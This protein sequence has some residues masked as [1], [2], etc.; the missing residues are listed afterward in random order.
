MSVVHYQDSTHLVDFAEVRKE[1]NLDW[2]FE[3]VLGCEAQKASGALRYSVCPNPECGAGPKSSVKV[4]TRNGV[5]QCCRCQRHGDVIEAAALV[6]GR[7]LAD[8]A[9]ELVGADRDLIRAYIPPQPN[10]AVE[11]DDTALAEVLTILTSKLQAPSR[12]GLDY[13]ASR[14][15][16][17]EIVRE[18][19]KKGML[20]TLPSDPKVAKQFLEK[21]VGRDLL[22]QAG[23][24]KEDKK[25]PP[26]IFR[27]LVLISNTRAAAEFRFLRPARQD[28][29]KML[30]CGIPVPWGWKGES[31]KRILI[32]EGCIDLLSAVALGTKRSVLGLPGCM[33]WRAE[34]FASF[35]GA[36]ILVAFD[37]D[38]AGIKAFE[39]IEPVLVDAVGGPIG[40][41]AL[42]PGAKDLNDQLM[43]QLGF[44]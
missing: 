16:S 28:E 14:G 24:W 38:D 10:S 19:C 21:E 12:E 6:T 7:S 42:P 5:W 15:I 4:R 31:T 20:L 22:H 40:K 39:A 34:W 9:K 27:P 11:R 1:V 43:I 13:L 32:T 18:A 29:V 44:K 33:N 36:D 25:A 8:A 23:L 41:Y 3:I 26:I 35:E 30:R 2:Y 17:A 37:N